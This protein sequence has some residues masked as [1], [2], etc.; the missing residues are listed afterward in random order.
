ME[1]HLVLDGRR[2]AGWWYEPRGRPRRDVAPRRS[3]G[4]SC[5]AD[6]HRPCKLL[7]CSFQLSARPQKLAG[8]QAG[9]RTETSNKLERV[10]QMQKAGGN[11]SLS[12]APRRVHLRCTMGD[13][14]GGKRVRREVRPSGLRSPSTPSTPVPRAASLPTIRLLP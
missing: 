11:A 4:A 1:G 12:R 3:R 14:R 2:V 8:R 5:T 13:Y 10:L 6:A 9:R 7:H